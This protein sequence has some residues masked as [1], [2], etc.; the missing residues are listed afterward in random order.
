MCGVNGYTQDNGLCS[1]EIQYIQNW[2]NRLS[3]TALI[4]N[5]NASIKYKS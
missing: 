3:S 2:V 1:I 5:W 4:V